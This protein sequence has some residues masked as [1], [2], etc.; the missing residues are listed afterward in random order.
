MVSRRNRRE[1]DDRS[2]AGQGVLF[3]RPNT[4]TLQLCRQIQRQLDL[5]F[6]GALEDPVLSGL[7]VNAVVSEPGTST[8]IVEVVVSDAAKA[9]ETLEHLNA[10]RGLLRSEIAAGIHRKY[11]PHLRFVVLPAA[12][13]IET[14]EGER[15]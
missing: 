1:R 10:A 8:F 11:T 14:I 2:T 4:K 13:V 5:T 15:S 6:G 9:S 12:A 7:S 3:E